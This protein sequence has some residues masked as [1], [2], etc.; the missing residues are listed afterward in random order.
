[1]GGK[2]ILVP[3]MVPFAKVLEPQVAKGPKGDALVEGPQ[4]IEVVNFWLEEVVTQR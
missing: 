3:I 2:V 1:M 4:R